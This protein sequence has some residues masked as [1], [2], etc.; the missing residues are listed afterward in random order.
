[1]RTKVIATTRIE[2]THAWPGCQVPGVEFLRHPHRHVFHVRVEC[3]VGHA[4][5]QRE[6]ID[7]G[8]SVEEHLVSAYGR[9]MDLGATSCEALALEL[10]EVV[11]GAV[12]AEVWEDG[13]NGARVER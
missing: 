8:R 4:D 5:R 11:D 13:E 2:G 10:V 1:M 3:E 12:G 7:L 9:P 6:F